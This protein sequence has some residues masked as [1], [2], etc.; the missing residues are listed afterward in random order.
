MTKKEIKE[1][2]A[3]LEKWQKEH[4]DINSLRKAYR[5][6]IPKQVWASMAFEGDHVSLRMLEKYLK[7][8]RRC[9]KK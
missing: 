6:N 7:E 3:L 5:E 4:S 1:A 9:E 8:M 2:Q